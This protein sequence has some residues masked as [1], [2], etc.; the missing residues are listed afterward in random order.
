MVFS[1]HCISF[2]RIYYLQSALCSG[3]PPAPIK[4]TQGLLKKVTAKGVKVILEDKVVVEVR[5]T[6]SHAVA[7]RIAA[8][9]LYGTDI[10]SLTRCYPYMLFLILTLDHA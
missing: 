1:I 7:V 2:Y 10:P 8:S 4:F 3:D 6:E 5:C 9:S